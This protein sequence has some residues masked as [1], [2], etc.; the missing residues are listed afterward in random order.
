VNPNRTSIP[1]EADNQ[2]GPDVIQFVMLALRRSRSWIL[3]LI[4]VGALVGGYVA[5]SQPNVYTSESKLLLRVGSRERV[6]AESVVTSPLDDS[7]SNPTLQAEIQMLQDEAIYQKVAR[8]FGPAEVLRAADPTRDDGDDTPWAVRTMHKVQAMVQGVGAPAHECT[9]GGCQKCIAAAV[10]NLRDNVRLEADRDS[11]VILVYY[12]ANSPERARAIT[13]ALVAAYIERHAEQFSVEPILEK[14]KPK[15][16][17]ARLRRES[18]SQAYFDHI[19]QC[20]IVDL[21]TQR[22]VVIEGSDALESAYNAAMLRSDEITAERSALTARMSASSAQI[23]LV[24][25]RA[26]NPKYLEMKNRVE[27]LD[28]EATT[29]KARLQRL[30]S[31]LAASKERLAGLRECERLHATLGAARNLEDARWREL[32]QRYSML[33]DLGSIDVQ[34]DSN[35]LVLQQATLNFKKDGPKRAKVVIAALAFSCF[36]GVWLALMREFFDRRLR[37]APMVERQLGVRLLGTI[38]DYSSRDLAA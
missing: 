9:P 35:L 21:E 37:H 13:Q 29:V 25:E 1:V 30:S 32:Q 12:T 7:S 2:S 18:S 23:D 10:E 20:G 24:R 15:L 8:D 31:D 3:P 27:D 22:R 38:P 28:V 11:N 6:T 34:S 5:L 33:E 26:P 4:V 17:A 19:Q 36:L 14:N 16:E